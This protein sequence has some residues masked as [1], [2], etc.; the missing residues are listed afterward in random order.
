MIASPTDRISHHLKFPNVSLERYVRARQ[1]VLHEFIK[2]RTTIYLDIKF[3]ISLRDVDLGRSTLPDAIELLRILRNGVATGVLLCPICESTFSELMKQSNGVTRL[4]TAKLIDELSLGIALTD[5]FTRANTELA[6]LLHADLPAESLFASDQLVWTKTAYVLG[7]I[8]PSNTPFDA[9]TEL[10]L[11]KAFV[12]VM[13]DA[14]LSD[15]VGKLDL[16]NKPGSGFGLLAISLNDQNEQH[17]D[18]LKSFQQTYEI[19]SQGAADCLLPA[20]EQIMQK[21][22][23]DKFGTQQQPTETELELGKNQLRRFLLSALNADQAKAVLRTMHI[24]T[25]LHAYL[26]WNK[27]QQWRENHFYDLHHAAAAIG[28]CALF[29]TEHGLKGWLTSGLLKLD[30]VYG[31]QVASSCQEALTLLASKASDS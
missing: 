29:F 27:G 20:A 7:Q 30:Q 18:E 4:A 15:I 11:Q 2:P 12:D 26:R 8:H 16:A 28:Y 5:Y 6:C 13:W 24:S 25:A 17:A 14:A 23:K 9:P 19:E 10:A 3:W 21:R 31:C 1:L 22:F